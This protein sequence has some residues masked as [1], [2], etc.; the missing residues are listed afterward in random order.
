MAA[1]LK[2]LTEN[3]FEYLA[4]AC[5]VDLRNAV[6]HMTLVI[7]GS[8]HHSAT[9]EQTRYG[10]NMEGVNVCIK[11]RVK[12]EPDVTKKVDVVAANIRLEGEVRS[13]AAA[14]S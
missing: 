3:W 1:K 9:D 4:N 10:F 8:A 13:Y 6:A 14:F 7:D 12:D 5:D 2:Y 11:R